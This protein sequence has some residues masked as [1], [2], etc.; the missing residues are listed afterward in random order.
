MTCQHL[1]NYA[2]IGKSWSVS[3]CA[4]RQHLYVPSLG[5][6]AQLCGTASHEK[7]PYFQSRLRA[8]APIRAI[9]A[10]LPEVP[11]PLAW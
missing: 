9:T 11:G 1:R 6:L 7:C 5:D 3:S 8:C 2:P 4:A 10:L